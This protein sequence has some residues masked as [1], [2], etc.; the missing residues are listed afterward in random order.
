MKHVS[1]PFMF[2]LAVLLSCAANP[3]THSPVEAADPAAIRA[4]SSNPIHPV[5]I[6]NEY[7]PLVRVVV[8]VTDATE[9]IVEAVAFQLDCTDDLESLTLFCCL[10]I[11]TL[12]KGERITRFR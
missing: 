12:R 10:P 3:I 6:R 5:L 4:A 8:D 9:I 11:H 1:K 2:S 7:G